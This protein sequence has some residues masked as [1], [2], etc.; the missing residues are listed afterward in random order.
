MNGNPSSTAPAEPHRYVARVYYQDTDAGG[1]AYHA[2]YLRFAERARTE[3]LRDLGV[4]HAELTALHNMA[5][6]VRR[7]EVD[8]AAPA[9]L[10]D[11]LLVLTRVTGLRPASVVLQQD[12]YREA[13]GREAGGREAGVANRPL[14]VAR[15][16][17][18]CVQADSFRPARIPQRWRAAL[19]ALAAMGIDGT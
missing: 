9:R 3:A 10:D 1:V 2:S 14:V 17:L 8:Y 18:A 4:A 15:V 5:F 11:C 12:F 19:G 16:W 6:V 13:G 7:V